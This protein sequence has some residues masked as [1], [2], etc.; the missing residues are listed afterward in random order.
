EVIV[1]TPDGHAREL[2]TSID[3]TGVSFRAVVRCDQGRGRY[4]VE[5]TGIDA[6]GT[7]VV[8]N[9][10]VF[11]GVAPPAQPP[12]ALPVRSQPWTAAESEAR[13]LDLVNRD[14][15]AAGLP[16]V[17]LDK[18]LSVVARAHSQDMADHGFVGH[19]SPSTGNA[20][21]RV[22]RSGFRPAL[23][24]ENVG[25]AYSPDEVEA[26]LMQSPG[27]R[28]NILYRGVTRIGIGVVVGKEVTGTSPLLVTQVFM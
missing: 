19:V 16:P 6:L 28:A 13:L 21:D 26:G 2:P 20:L 27:H 5:V 11:C 14:R 8:A 4:Q 23:L 7:A 3:A 10:P 22:R 17:A 24:L 1:T 25:R 18:A 15:R 9:F 12:A